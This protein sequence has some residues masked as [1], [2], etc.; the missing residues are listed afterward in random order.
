MHL[1][2]QI[3]S[4]PS[5][6]GFC[7]V[8]IFVVLFCLFAFSPF[9]S[10]LLTQQPVFPSM[11][12]HICPGSQTQT[13]P[14]ARK[15]M[16]PSYGSGEGKTTGSGE[17]SEDLESTRPISNLRSCCNQTLSQPKR[18]PLPCRSGPV[19]SHAWPLSVR[20]WVRADALFIFQSLELRKE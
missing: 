6:C 16:N 15:L 14:W 12:I 11:W 7:C 13:P 3:L 17:A 5:C 1:E 10:L 4:V 18:T 2:G 8:C 20:S 9:L 19:T